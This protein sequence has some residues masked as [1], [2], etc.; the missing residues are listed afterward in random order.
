MILRPLEPRPSSSDDFLPAWQVVE[1]L[2]Q[3]K[4][5]SC[6]LI[7][8][9]S[10][11]ALAGEVARKLKAPGFPEPDAQLLQAIALH[12]AGWGVLDTQAI[13]K[14]RSVHPHQPQ[15]FTAISVAQLIDAWTQ[16]IETCVST[17]PAGGYIV[18]GHFYRLAR[19][20]VNSNRVTSAEDRRM[21]EAFIAQEER[22]Q[23]KLLSRQKLG[24]EQLE[25]F[26][27][28]L[29]LCDLFSLYICCG[30]T[31]SV[32]F[33]EYCNIRLQLENRDNAYRLEPPLIDSGT[34][35]SVAALR[36]PATKQIS[37]QEIIFKIH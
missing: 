25:L 26:T 5:D 6:W 35:F 14:S 13:M 33:P 27:D 22:R 17:S 8:Q 2:Q 3:Q 21:L 36:Y 34:Q 23:K 9:P 11:A 7:T 10:H 4:Y 24:A 20:Q 19:H 15:P 18:S 16:S 32:V 30:A 28:F 12:D 31:E 1:S 37:S 29:Q